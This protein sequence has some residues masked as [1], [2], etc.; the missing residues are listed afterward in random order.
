[1]E[2]QILG[3]HSTE[4]GGLRLASLLIDDILLLDAGG[5]TASLSLSEQQQ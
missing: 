4:A 3:A 5:L 2:V 1:M